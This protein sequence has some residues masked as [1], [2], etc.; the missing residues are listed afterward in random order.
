M[1]ECAKVNTVFTKRDKFELNI[2]TKTK[3]YIPSG[4]EEI[5]FKHKI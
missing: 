5:Y 4:V 3:K 1:R 2:L